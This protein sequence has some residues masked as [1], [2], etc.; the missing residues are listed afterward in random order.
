M[1]LYAFFYHFMLL[2]TVV[3]LVYFSCR[4]G[5]LSPVFVAGLLVFGIGVPAAD[6]HKCPRC[7]HVFI[8]EK[9]SMAVPAALKESRGSQ[10]VE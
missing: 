2:A 7:N 8:E 5:M 1:W 6:I 10:K 4:H 3:S 9:L